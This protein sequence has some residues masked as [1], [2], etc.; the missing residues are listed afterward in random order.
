MECY[1][2]PLRMILH[3]SIDLGGVRKMMKIQSAG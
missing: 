3:V 2:A 1:A